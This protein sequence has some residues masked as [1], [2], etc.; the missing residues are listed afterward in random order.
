VGEI[1]GVSITSRDGRW[2]VERLREVGRADDVTAAA[3][4]EHGLDNDIPIDWLTNAERLAVIM[5]LI[6]A[7]GSF[8]ELRAT[9][10]ANLRYPQ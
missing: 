2:I 8:V 1:E 3:S 10:A 7:P 6:E 9:L 5:A 4:I